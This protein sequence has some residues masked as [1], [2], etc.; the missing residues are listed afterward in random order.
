[1]IRTMI[2]QPLNDEEREL[3][4]MWREIAAGPMQHRV[5]GIVMELVSFARDP[6]CDEMQGDGV[7]CPDAKNQCDNCWRI[8]EI[9]R[10]FEL[11]VPQPQAVPP[12]QLGAEE[13]IENQAW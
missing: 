8:V 13:E 12:A 3:L 9:L 6:H 10:Q 1:M 5:K 7:P 2:E 11:R 4:G